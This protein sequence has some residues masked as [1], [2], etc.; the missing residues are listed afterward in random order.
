[1]SIVDRVEPEDLL[2]PGSE[3]DDTEGRVG[4]GGFEISPPNLVTLFG[5]DTCNAEGLV[6]LVLGL[7][8]FAKRGFPCQ[9]YLVGGGV[10]G[11]N[12]GPGFLCL[13]LSR[14]ANG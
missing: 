10:G 7:G 5:V 12:G 8:E 3:I 1:M 13:G 2:S 9:R 4:L 6:S 11:C 14:P